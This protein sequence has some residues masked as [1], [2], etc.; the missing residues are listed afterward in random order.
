[1]AQALQV[2]P[3]VFDQAPI[4]G[5]TGPAVASPPGTVAVTQLPAWYLTPIA[6]IPVAT[7]A[8]VI[9]NVLMMIPWQA[10]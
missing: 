5:A 7:G 4:E 6:L 2:E 10:L 1:M 8:F 9:G 3:T